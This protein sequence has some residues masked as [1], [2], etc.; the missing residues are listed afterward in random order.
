MR[1]S[2]FFNSIVPGKKGSDLVQSMLH[3]DTYVI[4]KNLRAEYKRKKVIFW[5]QQGLAPERI[6]LNISHLV[7]DKI[8]PDDQEKL[9]EL[10]VPALNFFL[11]QNDIL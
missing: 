2:Y 6:L 7:E 3:Q 1:S 4:P 8:L 5:Q 11:C 10:D 9:T